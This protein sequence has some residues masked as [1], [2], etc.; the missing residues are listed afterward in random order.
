MAKTGV[1]M[2]ER[3]ITRT[4]NDTVSRGVQA[5]LVWRKL[6][7]FGLEA[8]YVDES[9]VTKV[10]EGRAQE[11]DLPTHKNEKTRL[12][13]LPHVDPFFYPALRSVGYQ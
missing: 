13:T 6:H 4:R 12:M 5:S 10:D 2:I 8:S 3:L 11:S 7:Q 1:A 9:S